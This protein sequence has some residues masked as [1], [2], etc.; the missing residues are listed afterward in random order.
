VKDFIALSSA[1]ATPVD[2]AHEDLMA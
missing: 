2:A 1:V